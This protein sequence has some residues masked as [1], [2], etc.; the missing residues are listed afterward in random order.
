MSEIPDLV[1]RPHHALCMRFFEG[2]G[3]SDTFTENMAYIQKILERENPDICLCIGQDCICR[4]CPHNQN[5]V[6]DS[7]EKVSR[8][9]QAVLDQTGITSGERVSWKDLKH[10]VDST[11]LRRGLRRK[12]C[13]DCQWN[14][15][16][17][18]A[19]RSAF[20]S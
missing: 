3:Y 6:C 13:G 7:Q 11:I 12:I 4:A 14:Q 1:L 16:C 20:E 18:S 9:D 5:G 2:K 8:Y 17:E 19:C 10:K 15:V